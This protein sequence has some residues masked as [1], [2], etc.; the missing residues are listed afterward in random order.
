MWS[1]AWRPRATHITSDANGQRMAQWRPSGA[2]TQWTYNA[3]SQR[4]TQTESTTPPTTTTW[5]YN[6]FDDLVRL[7]PPGLPGQAAYLFTPDANGQL[8]TLRTPLTLGPTQTWND[9]NLLAAVQAHPNGPTTT[10]TYNPRGRLETQTDG[11]GTRRF[12]YDADGNVETVTEGTV[13]STRTY[14]SRHRVKTYTDQ[15]GRTLQYAYDL[16]GNLTLLTY[17]DGKIVQY[18]YDAQDRLVRV[19]DWAGRDTFY[20]WDHANRLTRVVRPNGTT[21]QLTYDAAGQLLRIEERDAEGVLLAA[22]QLAYDADGFPRQRLVLPVPPMLGVPP[23]PTTLMGSSPPGRSPM[24][25]LW[26]MALM[27]ATASRASGASVMPTMWR[28]IVS[29]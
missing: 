4:E 5:Q 24:A 22:V 7:T 8:Q 11:L 27:C 16:H 26:P 14:D 2:T 12:T 9:R 6:A 19:H 18:D 15:R 13:G 1:S 21:R 25:P 29:P 23:S 20:T 10:F 28:I 3:R 17:P